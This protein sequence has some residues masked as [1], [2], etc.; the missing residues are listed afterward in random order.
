MP[1]PK[2]AW[3]LLLLLAC[4]AIALAGGSSVRPAQGGAA[5]KQALERLRVTGSVLMVAAHPDD[6]NTALLAWCA[7][8]RKLRAA[9]LSLTR[10]EGGQ[11]LIG[12]EQGDLLGLIRTQELLAARRIDGAEQYFTRAIDFGFSKSAAETIAKWGR[13]EVVS[14]IVWIIRKYRPDVIINRFSGTS[15]DGHGHH[16]ASALLSQEAFGLAGDPAAFPEQLKFVRPW[17]PKRL[18]WNGFSFD[19]Q[20]ERE[21]DA[22][23][24]RL[25]VDTGAYDPVLGSSYSELAGVSRSQHRSQGMGAPERRGAAPNYLVH[26]AGDP[27]AKDFFDGVDTTWSRLPG[28]AAIDKLLRQAVDDWRIDAPERAIPALCKVRPL[29]AAIDDPIARRKLADLDE[30]IAMAAGLWLDVSIAPGVATPESTAAFTLTAVNRSRAG[31]GLE[32]VRIIGPG[33]PPAFDTALPLEFNKP[34]T[35]RVDWTVP[36]DAPLVQPYWL[37]AP[38]TGLLYRVED[39]NLLGLAQ[40]PALLRARFHLRVDGQ[41]IAIDRPVEHRFVDRVRGEITEPFSLLPP[42]SLRLPA[43]S[44]IFPGAA[45]RSISVEVQANRPKAEGSVAL[46]LPAGWRAEPGVA[47]F[48]IPGAGQTAQLRFRVA[49]GSP[50]GELSAVATVAGRPIANGYVRITYDHIPP[51]TVQSPVTMRVTRED[52]KILSR[53]IGYVMGAGDLVPASLEQLGC[54]VTLLPPEDLANGD[55]SRFDAI[56]TGVRAWNVRMDLRINAPRLHAYVERG[57]TLLV[58]FNTTEGGSFGA[59]PAPI[60]GLGPFPLRLSRDRVSVEEAPVRILSPGHILLASPNVIRPEDF[61]GWVQERGL[62]FP[63]GLDLDP[64]YECPL[65]MNDPGE[66]PLRTGIVYA[67]VGRGAYIYTPLAWFRQLPAGV[68]GAFKLFANLLSAGRA[69]AER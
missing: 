65:E 35:Q 2:Y 8:G 4:P 22:T 31:I 66:K 34:F 10:G 23:P 55:L 32:R 16:Q 14:D 53:R 59:A 61:T 60:A 57:G 12:S 39:L 52:V 20:Q 6:E 46:V 44:M 48:S 41:S 64:R 18:L 49:P 54:E 58:Q 17:K 63:A 25:V 1:V 3:S 51:Q 69:A 5:L 30:T 37:A 13:R 24:N 38:P 36:P 21:M 68:P 26:V 67:R 40:A 33:T 62:Y 50:G 15:R 19:R 43:P 47:P 29:I 45:P 28:G 27:A 7:Q 11:N 56:V 42:V 9:Y